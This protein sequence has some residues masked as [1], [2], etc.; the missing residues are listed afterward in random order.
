MSRKTYS[1]NMNKF[2]QS[3]PAE[4]EA[5]EQPIENEI[6]VPVVNEEHAQEH[7]ESVQEIVVVDEVKEELVQAKKETKAVKKKPKAKM[8]YLTPEN[9]EY[10]DNEHF[11]RHIRSRNQFINEIITEYRLSEKGYIRK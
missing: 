9:D 4:E 6:P 7:K 3:M 8:I 11:E 10:I 2:L 5:K 1:S